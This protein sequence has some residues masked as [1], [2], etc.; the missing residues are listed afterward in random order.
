MIQKS[1]KSKRQP[2]SDP[3]KSR[4]KRNSIRKSATRN[5]IQN[6]LQMNESGFKQFLEAIPDGL[7]IVNPQEKIQFINKQVGEMFGYQLEEMLGK[8][9]KLLIPDHF[10]RHKEHREGY[11]N[12]LHTRQ[13]AAGSRSRVNRER[14]PSS[15]WFCQRMDVKHERYYLHPYC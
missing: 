13:M 6:G 7:V 2:V 3:Q 11:L 9:I 14:V 12:N 10:N 8:P 15:R 5:P 1:D 4:D